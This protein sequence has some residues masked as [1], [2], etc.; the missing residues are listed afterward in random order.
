MFSAL[1]VDCDMAVLADLAPLWEVPLG[2]H[3]VAAVCDIAGNPDERKA[4]ETSVYFNSGLLVVDLELWR[5]H[6]VAG[7]LGSTYGNMGR[8]RSG[9]LEPCAGR[10]VA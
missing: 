8:T 9:R 3:V 7:P 6:N 1:E 2:E 4:I 10:P 5:E